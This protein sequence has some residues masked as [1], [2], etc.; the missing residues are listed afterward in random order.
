MSFFHDKARLFTWIELGFRIEHFKLI[1]QR[2][3]CFRKKYWSLI[4]RYNVA[5]KMRVQGFPEELLACVFI[6][7][8]NCRYSLCRDRY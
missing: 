6:V 7:S 8:E 4:T 2:R 1:F 5:L 3:Y